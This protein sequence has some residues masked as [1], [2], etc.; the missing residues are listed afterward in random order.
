M[1]VRPDFWRGR[2]VLITGHTGFKGSWLALWLDVLGARVT[3]LALPPENSPSN[4]ELFGP[5]NALESCMV[6]LRDAAAV[7]STMASA[8]PEIVIHLAAQSL[9][10]RGY[11]DPAGT[12]ATN[13]MGGAHLLEA[14]RESENLKVI[15]FV[16]SDKVY[17]NRNLGVPFKEDDRLGGDDPYGGS[18]A[19]AELMVETWRASFLAAKG[20]SITTGRAGNVI[21]GGDGSEARLLPDAVRA[22]S[23]GEPIRLRNP[24]GTRPWQFVLEPLCGYLLLAQRLFE[25]PAG[26]PHAFNFGPDHDGARRV[27]EVI[28]MVIAEWGEGRWIEEPQPAMQEAKLL[29]LDPSL[30][31]QVLGWRMRLE[32]RE[33]IRWLVAWYKALATGEN[34]RAF[35]TR[36]IQRYMEIA[37]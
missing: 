25:K 5:W 31:K 4:F 22:L 13:V 23:A 14:A 7:R 16:T 21:G 9:M 1:G 32:L 24:G 18:K 28:D 30:A 17:L 2:R 27:V 3:A 20:I 8:R 15:V 6:D 11:R 33:A 29:S 37:Q 26:C 12:W 35:S 34:M 19:A 10:P 36:Q